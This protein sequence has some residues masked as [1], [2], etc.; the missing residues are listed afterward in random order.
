MFHATFSNIIKA[1]LTACA[2]LL[3]AGAGAQQPVHLQSPD[4][5]L[6]CIIT[7][8]KDGIKYEVEYNKTMLISKSGLSLQ[9]QDGFSLKNT[10]MMKPAFRDSV[11]K[12]DL[13][14]GRSHHVESHY[15]EVV[16]PFRDKT[17]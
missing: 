6:K 8:G 15:R 12:Y 4:K 5:K 3:F 10:L 13:L 9:L 1:P 16:I 7:T 11:E 14:I 17:I 2:L